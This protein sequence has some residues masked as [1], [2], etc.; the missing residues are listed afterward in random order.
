MHQTQGVTLHHVWPRALELSEIPGIVENFATAARNAKSAGFDGVEI[1]GANGYLLD[2]FL[3]QI[4]NR[5]DD[6]YGGS[7]ENRLRFALEVVDAV[8]AEMGAGGVGLRLSPAAYFGLMEH[9]SGDEEAYSRLIEVLN[10]R[11]LAYL[12]V[13]IHDDFEPYD[14]LGGRASAFMRRHFDGTLMGNGGYDAATAAGEISSGAVD[15][16][17]F[18]RA[19]IANPDL[20]SRLAAGEPL[21]PYSPRIARYA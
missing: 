12:H 19:F 8:I 3:R 14:Y 2:Q 4:T 9:R 18:G 6:A 11:P 1:H 20:V 7:L 16:V 21:R 5:R 10:S 13:A 15:L 17:S